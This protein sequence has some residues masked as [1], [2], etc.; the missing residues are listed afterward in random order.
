MR[1]NVGVVVQCI[2][3][4]HLTDITEPTCV[5][6]GRCGN[7]FGIGILNV[8]YRTVLEKLNT[9]IWYVIGKHCV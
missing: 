7:G 8:I 1:V 3:I 5:C 6:L 4:S 9:V 2:Y